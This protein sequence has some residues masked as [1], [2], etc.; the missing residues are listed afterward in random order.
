MGQH[1]LST[2]CNQQGIPLHGSHEMKKMWEP[3]MPLYV[4]WPMSNYL[5]K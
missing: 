4:T 3:Q 1:L 5:L 2:V